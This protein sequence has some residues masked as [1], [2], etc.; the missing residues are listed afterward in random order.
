MLFRSATSLPKQNFI[1]GQSGAHNHR[2]TKMVGNN[3]IDGVD[4]TTLHSG[5]HHNEES[6]TSTIGDH[7]HSISGGD[8]ETRSKNAYVNYIIRVK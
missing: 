4:S 6:D 5:E 3:D 2:Y 1:I 7:S 8:S